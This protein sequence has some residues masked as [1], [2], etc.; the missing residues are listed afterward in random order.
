MVGATMS[1]NPMYIEFDREFDPV[2]LDKPQEVEPVPVRDDSIGQLAREVLAGSHG[3]TK[4]SR[5]AGLGDRYEAVMEEV[6]RIRL[7]GA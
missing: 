4:A 3:R 6:I 5:K 2:A 1:E 7:Q